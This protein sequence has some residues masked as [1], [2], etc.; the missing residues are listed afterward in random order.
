[1]GI[2]S[3][4]FIRYNSSSME[5]RNAAYIDLGL[6]YQERKERLKDIYDKKYVKALC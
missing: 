3:K 1:M 4:L 2:F 5:G 6:P